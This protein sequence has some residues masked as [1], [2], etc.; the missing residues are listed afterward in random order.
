MTGQ[1]P[2]PTDSGKMRP[3]FVGARDATAT[4]GPGP[5]QGTWKVLWRRQAELWT[6]E[7]TRGN[8]QGDRLVLQYV[9]YWERWSR[10]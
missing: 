6:H 5:A 3:P 10:D 2:S 7:D 4:Q 1:V 9:V 8:W